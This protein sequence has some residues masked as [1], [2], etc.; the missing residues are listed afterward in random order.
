M[1][2][3]REA[4]PPGARRKSI[5][6]TTT[7]GDC[8]SSGFT[9]APS[10]PL[11]RWCV[12]SGAPS[13][14]DLV[15]SSNAETP[16]FCS[17][18]LDEPAGAGDVSPSSFTLSPNESR[19]AK[20]TLFSNGADARRRAVIVL[21][22]SD[23]RE[24]AKLERELAQAGSADCSLSLAW[25]RPVM[26]S[27]RP[28][29][30]VLICALKNIG[31]A[32][33]AFE[34]QFARHPALRFELPPPVRL[35]AGAFADVP[36]R[37]EWDRGA[38]D[39]IGKNHPQRIDVSVNTSSGVRTAQLAWPVVEAKLEEPAPATIAWSSGDIELVRPAEH[40]AA[41]VTP[42]PVAPR[43]SSGL[44]APSPPPLPE[45]PPP[46]PPPEPPPPLPEPPPARVASP[47]APPPEQPPSAPVDAPTP[48][49]KADV[50]TTRI[51]E[52]PKVSPLASAV[53]I[54][55]DPIKSARESGGRFHRRRDPAI[56]YSTLIL[57]ILGTIA[58]VV[59]ILVFLRP[60]P[61]PP[62][63]VSITT[64]AP[65]I[66]QLAP[67]RAKPPRAAR[68]T[69]AH[70]RAEHLAQSGALAASTPAPAATSAPA[71]AS[72]STRK[73]IARAAHRAARP[74][75]F[76]P[77]GAAEPVGLYS[78]YANWVARG[79]AVRVYWTSTGQTAAQVEVTNA[80]GRVISQRSL[81]GAWQTALLFIPRGFHGPAYVQLVSIGR[82]GD[83]VAQSTQLSAY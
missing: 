11:A 47:G 59:A 76:R 77:Q 35:E 2:V 24:L 82:Q 13:N 17:L 65:L 38:T 32:A 25:Q 46:E 63:T 29:G 18:A 5:R 3:A 54:V 50:W 6:Y 52:A 72:K 69:A 12:S 4:E 44:Q 79:R 43:R 23:G 68:K 48:A 74:P 27:G 56:R 8:M 19:T 55:Q 60:S 61:P 22:A 83:R 81:R 21:R 7:A 9:L 28:R 31:D 67:V 20:L 42:R 30:F 58:L 40:A 49:V 64:P 39:M 36:V 37:V 66:A 57:T 62:A 71:P 10:N 78:V 15:V 26:Q 41:P 70:H 75:V 51:P 14:F 34:L 1:F 45:P 16:V 33:G 53:T 73:T 80:N